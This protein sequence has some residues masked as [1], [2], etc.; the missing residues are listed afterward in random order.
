[1]RKVLNFDPLGRNRL[2]GRARTS[3]F[4]RLRSHRHRRD[5]PE[6][7]YPEYPIREQSLRQES[8]LINSDGSF[9]RENIEILDAR[10]CAR[11]RFAIGGQMHVTSLLSTP[12]RNCIFVLKFY[13]AFRV[14]H[15]G[16]LPS[17]PR[18]VSHNCASRASVLAETSRYRIFLDTPCSSGVIPPIPVIIIAD[19]SI[20]LS[21][22]SLETAS[23]FY[24]SST[25]QSFR[26][27]RG[28]T[29]R[30]RGN[31]CQRK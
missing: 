9:E 31:N 8:R 24:P 16:P 19:R 28:S 26:E 1:M 2:N 25:V 22:V 27:F 3:R 11:S 6:S 5:A 23:S 12:R 7:F 10:S 18:Y 30:K 17:R 29:R 4:T 20:V 13:A 14:N 21:N 15:R